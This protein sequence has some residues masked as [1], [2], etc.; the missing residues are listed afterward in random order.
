V[1]AFDK[2]TQDVIAMARA[3]PG[4]EQDTVI[5]TLAADRKGPDR[6]AATG[7]ELQALPPTV[8]SMTAAATRM[9]LEDRLQLQDVL[10]AMNGRPAPGS[11]S[12]PR[13]IMQWAE[14]F[15]VDRNRMSDYLHHGPI[16]ARKLGPLWQVAVEDVPD[17][18]C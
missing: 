8:E 1:G 9:S 16:N 6:P 2:S 7:E 4:R 15:G 13:S 5:N 14:V 12:K 10:E 11:W 18:D 17:P 3:L